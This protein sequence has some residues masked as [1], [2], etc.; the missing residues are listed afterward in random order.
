MPVYNSP[1]EMNKLIDILRT[2]LGI[3]KMV[4]RE[5]IVIPDDALLNMKQIQTFVT[6]RDADI[7]SPQYTFKKSL[8]SQAGQLSST[9]QA[10]TIPVTNP[11]DYD[12]NELLAEQARLSL[13]CDVAQAKLNQATQA[14]NDAEFAREQHMNLIKAVVSATI[15][16]IKKVLK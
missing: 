7:N 16:N 13:C 5:K 11:G 3:N 12:L 1:E 8:T 10:G 2:K 15:E 14:A 6:G 4:E 9:H